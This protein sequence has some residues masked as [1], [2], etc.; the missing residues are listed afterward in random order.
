MVE[1]FNQLL[2]SDAGSNLNNLA[3]LIFR[4]LLSV[5][6]FGVHGLKKFR[7]KDGQRE[8]EPNPFNLPDKLNTI[9]AGLS[10][11]IMPFAVML[12]IFTRL[13]VLPIIG[14]TAIGYFVVHRKD[15]AEIRD[16]PYMYTLSF[17]L[18]LFLGAG[19]YSVDH[20]LISMIK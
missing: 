8:K 16:V 6:L 2:Y 18:L 12:G 4:V 13:A 7:L 5:E 19:T 20:Y 1:F 15:N 3:L 11:K 14:V 17:L 10:D 9:L